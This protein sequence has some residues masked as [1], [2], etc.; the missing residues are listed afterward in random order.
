M[1]PHGV[2][3]DAYIDGCETTLRVVAQGLGV[4]CPVPGIL[5]EVIDPPRNEFHYATQECE[6]MAT[7]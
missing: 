7:S 4:E 3:R 2:E 5:V 1:M 6:W